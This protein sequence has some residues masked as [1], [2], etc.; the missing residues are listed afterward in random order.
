MMPIIYLLVA[1]YVAL[2]LTIWMHE[3]GHTVVYW[4][5]GCEAT[6]LESESTLLFVSLDAGSGQ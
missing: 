5:F 3:V 1:L 2:Y 4:T 6:P